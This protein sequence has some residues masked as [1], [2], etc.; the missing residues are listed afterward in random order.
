MHADL[1]ANTWRVERFLKSFGDILV[2]QQN[3]NVFDGAT[4]SELK[5][6]V[7]LA[8]DPVQPTLPSHPR[9]YDFF[10]FIESEFRDLHKM[11]VGNCCC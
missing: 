5:G 6:T 10:D 7:R 9:L 1:Q 3:T 2:F 11:C 8:F 4:S